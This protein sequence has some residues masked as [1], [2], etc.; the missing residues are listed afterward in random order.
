MK[1][2]LLCE[3]EVC[4]MHWLA[5]WGG[6]LSNMATRKSCLIRGQPLYAVIGGFHL[7][8]E[9]N[10]PIDETIA[11]FKGEA[12]EVLLLMHCVEFP[13]LVAFHNAFGSKKYAAGDVITL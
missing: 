13:A 1:I 8:A 11:Y 3:N 7:L 9:D 2:T 12:P 4:S 5:E 10:P 6:R